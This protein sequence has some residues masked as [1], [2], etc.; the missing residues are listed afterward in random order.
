MN[1]KPF[2][3]AAVVA[4]TAACTEEPTVVG[5]PEEVELND[6]GT[7]ADVAEGPVVQDELDNGQTRPRELSEDNPAFKPAN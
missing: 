6:D 7:P 2:I 5:V 4:L 3:A 1:I